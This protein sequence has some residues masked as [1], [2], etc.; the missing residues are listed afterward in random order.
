M[1]CSA[2]EA[3]GLGGSGVGVVLT[4]GA[5]VCTSSVLGIF[6]DCSGG[7]AVWQEVRAAKAAIVMER[8]VVFIRIM[9]C[10]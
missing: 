3:E 7:A 4:M 2:G 10:C 9:F 8:M 5:D 1:V 6:A